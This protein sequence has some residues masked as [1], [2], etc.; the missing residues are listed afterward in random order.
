[1]AVLP[2]RILNT[3]SREFLIFLKN[4][5]RYVADYITLRGFTTISI[6]PHA[7]LTG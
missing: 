4:T 3:I 6:I 5:D 2:T 7:L 1:M